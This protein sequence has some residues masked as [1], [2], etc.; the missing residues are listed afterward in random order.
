MI[1]VPV[2]LAAHRLPVC[3]CVVEPSSAAAQHD[4]PDRRAK[5]VARGDGIGYG[6]RARTR[7]GRQM[8]DFAEQRKNM[9]EAQVRP[10]DITDRRITRAMLELPR[11]AFCPPS[12]R[13]IAYRDEMLQIND[14]AGL[15]ARYTVA[16][17]ILAKLIQA[18]DLG[19][20]DSVLELG[21]GTGYTTA[22]L[23]RIA[24]KVIAVEADAVLA[25]RARTALAELTITNVKVVAG[26]PVSGHAAGAPYDAILIPAAVAQIPRALLDQL[27]DGGRLAAVITTGMMGRLTQW[28][29]VGG[30]FDSRVMMEATAPAL[31]GFERPKTFVF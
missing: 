23:A 9:V 11:E 29:R 13:A 17:R 27:K 10:S 19:E 31:A 14:D 3:W 26:D 7:R 20:R 2:S 18:L 25:E 1:M 5:P 24:T 16:P 15:R 21:C 22:L 12:Q 30:T 4:G 28:R 8:V 6:P